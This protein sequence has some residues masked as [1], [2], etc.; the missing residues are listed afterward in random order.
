MKW[1]SFA[2]ATTI[3]VGAPQ[4]ANASLTKFAILD[5]GYVH[6]TA[7]PGASNTFSGGGSALVS[8]DRFNFQFDASDARS[9]S[10]RTSST[11]AVFSGD[12]FWRSREGTFGV[13]VGRSLFHA[14]SHDANATG[15]GL[16]GEWY[17]TRNITLAIRGGAFSG[18]D[19]GRYGDLDAKVY[20]LPNMAVHTGYNYTGV[21]GGSTSDFGV[22]LEYLLARQAP[23]SLVAAYHHTSP[24]GGGLDINTFNIG[25]R[26]RFG[27]TGA[28][29]DL[30]RGGS[31]SWNGLPRP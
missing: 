16:F 30:D 27:I 24:N 25:F 12:F 3:A 22:G 5:V 29:V 14:G 13:S 19:S 1:L 11:T 31:L 15:Y 18:F 7:G 21:S 17:A 23:L 6:T 10:G 9:G 20:L 2:I 4:T 26:Y 8:Y 28:L